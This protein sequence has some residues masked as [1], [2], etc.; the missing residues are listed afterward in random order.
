MVDAKLSLFSQRVIE[1][2]SAIPPGR[3]CSYGDIAGAAESPRAARQVVRVL[4]SLSLKY[5]LPWHRV[6]NRN[7]Q[8]AS[9]PEIFDEQIQL[10]TD[11]GVSLVLGTVSQFERYRWRPLVL[12]NKK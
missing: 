8:V 6:V 9:R 1:L 11:E 12:V 2:V 3:V 7:G 4:H 5:Q 10:L